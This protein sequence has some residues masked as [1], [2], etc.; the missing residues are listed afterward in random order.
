M[1]VKLAVRSEQLPTTLFVENL[2]LLQHRQSLC[3]GFADVYQGKL[4]GTLVAVKKTRA[5]G[6]DSSVYQV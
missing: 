5:V 1:L 2:S 3:G 4:R 6:G